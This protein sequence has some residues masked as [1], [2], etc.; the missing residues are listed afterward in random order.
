MACLDAELPA[1]QQILARSITCQHIPLTLSVHTQ[2]SYA[3]S[4][5][6]GNPPLLASRHLDV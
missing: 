5:V 2:L 1:P 3:A 6:R 4:T